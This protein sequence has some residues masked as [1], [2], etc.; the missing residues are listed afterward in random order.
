MRP[1]FS[2][3]GGIAIDGNGNGKSDLLFHST[4][5]GEF[6]GV[7]AWKGF[8][9]ASSKFTL[10]FADFTVARRGGGTPRPLPR[11][12]PTAVTPYTPHEVN[13]RG[14]LIYLAGFTKRS[15]IRSDSPIA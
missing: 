8:S 12:C 6:G 11:S 2:K 4:A 1:S 9:P 5:Q 13:R 15:V 14:N 10:K 3:R 7:T